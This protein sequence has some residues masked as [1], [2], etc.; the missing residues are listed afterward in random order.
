MAESIRPEAARVAAARALLTELAERKREIDARDRR[1]RL[2]AEAMAEARAAER[3]AVSAEIAAA[4]AEL[5][6][7]VA[8]PVAGGSTRRGGCRT[9]CSW[10]SC[11]CCR[12]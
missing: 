11:C 3:A 5:A 6:A 9:S 8:A 1:E 4:E 10:Q 12:R 7:A 2:E